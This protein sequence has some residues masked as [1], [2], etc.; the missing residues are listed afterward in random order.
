[1]ST[2]EYHYQQTALKADEWAAQSGQTNPDLLH[3]KDYMKQ[4]FDDATRIMTHQSLSDEAWYTKEVG[5][6]LSAVLAPLNLAYFSGDK[7][8]ESY[9]SD[10]VLTSKA[11]QQLQTNIASNFLLNYIDMVIK[12]TTHANNQEITIPY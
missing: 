9:I 3:H 12:E 7:I 11:Y 4:V 1:M 8:P 5:D 10:T 6:E 2:H